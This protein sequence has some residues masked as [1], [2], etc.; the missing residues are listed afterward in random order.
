MNSLDENG[1]NRIWDS[2]MIWRRFE[3]II[4]YIVIFSFMV[5]VAKYL[6]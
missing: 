4:Y 1:G 6:I 2:G 3:D 5:L